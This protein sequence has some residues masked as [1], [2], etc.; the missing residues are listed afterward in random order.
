MKENDCLLEV[1]EGREDNYILPFLWLHGKGEE[2][3]REY[4]QKIMD[5][6]IRAVCLE[7]RPH[8]EF[9]REGWWK[10]VAVVLNEAKKRGMKVWILDDSHFPTGYAN[11]S[12]RQ[13]KDS[14]K[15]KFLVHREFDIEGP[16]NDYHIRVDLYN[17]LGEKGKPLSKHSSRLVA[18]LMTERRKGKMWSGTVADITENYCDGWLTFHVPEGKYRISIILEQTGGVASQEDYINMLDKDSVKLLID[19]VYESHYIHFKEYFGNTIAGF[20][21]D[22][23]GF[24]NLT[25]RTGFSMDMKIGTEMPLPWDETVEQLLQQRLGER[26]KY[27]LPFL[28]FEGGEEAQ[29]IRFHYMDIITDLY[30]DNFSDYLGKW[31]EDHGVEYIGHI[32]EDNNTHAR[33]GPSCGHYFKALHGQHMS[34]IDVVQHQIMPELNDDYYS[35]VLN[36]EADGAFYYYGLAKLG[37]SMTHLES[38]TKG[39]ALCELYGAYGWMEGL[40]LM[41]WLT[42]HMLVRGINTYVPHAF[43]DKEF[44]DPDCPPHFYANGKDPQ[45][46]YM[47]YLFQYLNRACHLLNGGKAVVHAAVLY[48]AELEWLGE[49]LMFHQIGKE[50]ME[51]QTD[52]DVV[53]MEKLLSM[54]IRDGILSGEGVEYRCL[55][56]P[57]AEKYPKAL[58]KW[59]NKVE[60]S[61]FPVYQVTTEQLKSEER[62][63]SVISLDKVAELAYCHNCNDIEVSEKIS[64]LRYYHYIHENI[65]TG[66]HMFFNESTLHEVDTKI[67]LQR[68]PDT[69]LYIYDPYENCLSIR[70]DWQNHEIGLKLQPAETLYLIETDRSYQAKAI[71]NVVMKTEKTEFEFEISAASYDTPEKIEYVDTTYQLKDF[72]QWRPDFAGCIYYKTWMEKQDTITVLQL[73]TAYDAVEVLVN[74]ISAGVRINSPY[75]YDLTGMLDKNQNEVVIKIATNLVYAQ[76]DRFSRNAV[77]AP[78]GLV[79]PVTL[80]TATPS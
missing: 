44:P 53:P 10:D 24:Y 63:S 37:T 20:F 9:A 43:S 73:G 60:E 30:R 6:G 25:T 16:L 23:P 70:P 33:L 11:G 71:E 68:K 55:F 42:D 74:G 64:Y 21:S 3:I 69:Q 57:M 61:G 49:C 32:I 28:W 36:K 7:S 79:G 65:N 40:G 72:F 67:K 13:A 1:L 19:E 4:I 80:E 34:G 39:R 8:P 62:I 78:M 15:R 45:Y 59:I 35:F 41:K 14:L 50:L 22:E 51:N 29:N 76:C 31:C 38:K 77:I 26:I 27:D 17:G 2:I 52:Y 56:V 75:R 58:V 47:K 18:C 54:N 48:H 5:T 66:I 12:V 46:P